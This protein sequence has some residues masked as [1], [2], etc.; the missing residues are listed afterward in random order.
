MKFTRNWIGL[1]SLL[2][3]LPLFAGDITISDAWIRV[4]PQDSENGMVGL[5]ITSPQKAKIIAASS[6]A[7]TSAEVRRLSIIKGEQKMEITQSISLTANNP[8]VLGPDSVHLALLG[9]KQTLKAGEKVPVI[10]TVQYN[11]KETTDITFL[12]QP[13]RARTAKLPVPLINKTIQAPAVAVLN[14]EMAILNK[15]HAKAAEPRPIES[16]V[17]MPPQI[18]PEVALSKQVVIADP[19]PDPMPELIT[20]PAEEPVPEPTTASPAPQIT[21]EIKLSDLPEETSILPVEDCLQYATATK[22][23]DHA[24]E[25]DEIMGCRKIV[26]TKFSCS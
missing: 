13:V 4:N 25:L 11:D 9:N 8:L 17:T 19:I 23:C 6:P 14:P 1:L 18:T 12:A 15:E 7:Y 24:G 20:K 3:S 26:K 2:F 10:V 22:V 5:T 16:P 21:A